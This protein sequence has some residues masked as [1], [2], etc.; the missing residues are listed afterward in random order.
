MCN[1]KCEGERGG[2][3][4]ARGKG[5]GRGGGGG[6]R[7]ERHEPLA[8]QVTISGVAGGGVQPTHPPT[9]PPTQSTNQPAL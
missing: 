6:G 9:H 2:G 4:A 8:K 5:M 1:V 3:W 7:S